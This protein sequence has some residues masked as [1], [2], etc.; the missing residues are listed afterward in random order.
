M[1]RAERRELY[2]RFVV[3]LTH[4]L[5]WAYQPGKRS[6]SWVDL[7]DVQRLDIRK[8]LLENPS[9]KALEQAIFDD[10]SARARIEA[11]RQT[12]LSRRAFPSEPPFTLDEAKDEAFWPGEQP[13]EGWRQLD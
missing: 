9:L 3:L 2:R 12:R 7:S 11:A 1:A 13:P 5:K 8:H 4:L 6:K 10:A